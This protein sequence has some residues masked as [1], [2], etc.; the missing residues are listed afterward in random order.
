VAPRDDELEARLDAWAELETLSE[1]G[2]LDA[3]TV[4]ALVG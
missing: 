4:R 1:E 2:A 3:A